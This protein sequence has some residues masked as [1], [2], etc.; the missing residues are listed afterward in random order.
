MFMY[1]H[2]T[3]YSLHQKI[4]FS[5]YGENAIIGAQNLV[6]IF[7]IWQYNKSIGTGEKILL[8]LFFFTYSFLLFQD[9]MITD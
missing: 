3:T 4:P 7:L 9:T 2:T 6:I 1:L 5:V 8:S